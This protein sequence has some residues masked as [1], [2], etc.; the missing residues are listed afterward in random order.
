MK[1]KVADHLVGLLARLLWRFDTPSGVQFA[2]YRF[3]MRVGPLAALA[4]AFRRKPLHADWR[5]SLMNR[6][7]TAFTCI[8]PNFTLHLELEG[9][10]LLDD[11]CREGGGV[12]L[13][14]AHF[15]LTLAAHAGVK[16]VG[17]RPVLVISG[18]NTRRSSA[19]W[20][21]GTPDRLEMVDADQPDV[22][23]KCARLIDKGA[24]LITFVDYDAGELHGGRVRAISPNLFR[25][26]QSKRVS[27]LFLASRLA[28]SGHVVLEFAKPSHSPLA[29]S[30]EAQ[31][32]AEEFARFVA[33]R[34][35]DRC[36][37]R[38]RKDG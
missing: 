29:G 20:N 33:E 21:W 38:R 7:L 4:Y 10:D 27:T 12:V 26:A 13:C 28:S 37:V 24:V 3:I 8:D 14:T 31:A 34:T 19:G 17:L 18:Q 5:V 2:A 32:C 1:E 30:K 23:R 36:V 25:W 6:F 15:G 16:R 9:S 11:A 35:G 22:L